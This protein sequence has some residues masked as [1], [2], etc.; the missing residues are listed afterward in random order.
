MP[1]AARLAIPI[2]SPELTLTF[3]SLLF[4]GALILF[5]LFYAGAM[6]WFGLGF[7]KVRRAP[8]VDEIPLPKISVIVPARNEAASIKVCVERILSNNYPAERFELIVV[9]DAS[10]DATPAILRKLQQKHAGAVAAGVEPDELNDIS[11]PELHIIHLP[12]DARRNGSRKRTALEAGISAATGD[13]LLTTDADCIVP[14]SWIRSMAAAFD[15]DTGFV[16][17]P[18]LYPDRGSVWFQVQALEFLGL[19]AI[20]AG[21]IGAGRP[22]LCNG[23]NAA[24]RKE[25]YENLNGFEG[26]ADGKAGDDE[27]LMWKV[28][29]SRIWKVKFCPAPDSAVLTA[30]SPNIK[31]FLRQRL[32]WA[33]L[34][35]SYPS[36]RTTLSL[37]AI[38][39]FYLFLAAGILALPFYPPLVLPLL[40]VL[41]LKA[42]SEALVLVPACHHFGRL[43][44]LVWLLPAQVFQI[45]YIVY[46]AA[47]GTLR[48]YNWT[49]ASLRA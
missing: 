27:L 37:A 13:L 7:L 18:V 42:V 43:R 44:L 6:G 38:F 12:H 10:T 35:S 48:K 1:F 17:G 25:V 19:V 47:A 32:R 36:L 31:T 28:A 30:P 14:Q 41:L 4:T 24:Y 16:A 11:T 49:E 34:A 40:A 2:Q 26:T 23:A 29:D 3:M 15:A 39:L 8:H 5:G 33:S 46:C 45:F 9:D 22:I 20:G 21:A